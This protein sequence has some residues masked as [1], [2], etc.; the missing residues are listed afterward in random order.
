MA[1][2]EIVGSIQRIRFAA[3]DSLFKIA[4]MRVSEVREGNIVKNSFGDVVFKGEMSLIPQ[5][6]YI[7]RGEFINDEKYGPQYQY[8]SSKRRDPIE[9]MSR[10]NFRQ[11][12][13][14]I[15]PKGALVNAQFD[16]PRPIFQEHRVK[17]LM[18]IKGIGPVSADKLINAY[19][20]QKDYSEAYVAFGKWGFN[21]NMTRKLVRHV[22][23]VEGAI[24]MLNKDPYEFM[25]VPGVGF[26]TIDEKALNFGIPSNDPRRV[27]AFVKDYFDKLAMDGSSW[28]KEIDLMKYLRQ[29]VFDCDVE[30]TLQWI[31]DSDEF[32][33]Y[34]AD[35]VRRVATKRLYNTEKSIAKNL[36]RLLRSENKFEY[37]ERDKIIDRIQEEQGWKYSDEQ[38][39]AINMML[40][41]NV[42]MLQGL[43]GTG[44][45]TA[46]NAVIKVLQDNDYQ[47]ATCALS[48]K[49]ADN[50]TQLTGK[51]GQTIHRMLGINEMGVFFNHETMPFTSDVVILD[52]VSM[53]ADELFEMLVNALADGTKFIMV[54]DVAQLDSIG[55]GVMRSIIASNIVPTISLTKIHRQA[56]DSA[57]I[58]HSLAY[59]H[60][61]LPQL[62][63]NDNWK[64]KG[65]KK[66][67]GYVF[68]N[69]AEEEKLLTD[70]YKV[71]A[72][73]FKKY[74][75]TDIQILTQTVN[76]TKKINEM[77]QKIANPKNPKKNQYTVFQGKEGE[78]VLREGDKVLN[79]ANKYKTLAAENESVY[80]PI[81]NGNTGIIESIE[82]EYDKKGNIKDIEMIIDFDGIG[83]VLL[84]KNDVKTIQLGYAMTVH[85]SQGS[86][87][88]CVI[89]M[90]PFHF[91]LNTRELLYTALTRASD[92]CFL[93]TTQKSLKTTVKKTSETVHHS[94]LKMLLE[95]EF[96]NAENV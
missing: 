15:S 30:E 28:T 47:V 27:H 38:T 95:E 46:L 57:I 56:E 59:R 35:D 75:V 96:K 40:D 43:A 49:A 62:S 74:P 50:L 12:L 10:E 14:D 63:L 51:R 77:A 8:I 24:E 61:N 39:E 88:P 54:G 23:S 52:E 33:I 83:R 91:M 11:F 5:N 64:M 36:L 2:I 78:Y 42:S 69:S 85:K 31:N 66:D 60:G 82:Y 25:S 16:D 90:L 67:L 55:V 79:T 73:A 1:E 86:T 17:E 48:G 3:N 68:E 58:T 65:N 44:K 80:R 4:T 72:L 53:V 37:K 6:E 92:K 93:L 94:N 7:I 45:S 13:T 21:P 84:K 22:H 70:A 32:V 18:S 20:E 34:E 29:E 89:V 19:E 87:I 76:N 81:F 71:F 41:K 26:K 9:G